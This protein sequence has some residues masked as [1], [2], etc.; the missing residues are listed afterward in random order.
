MSERYNP[1]MKE[2]MPPEMDTHRKP[3]ELPVEPWRGH[4]DAKTEQQNVI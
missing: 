3:A 4:A 1:N 2:V